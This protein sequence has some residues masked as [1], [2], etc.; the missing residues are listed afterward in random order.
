M[1]LKKQ[2]NL[3]HKSLKICNFKT[4]LKTELVTKD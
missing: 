3:I 2:V 4:T 1:E